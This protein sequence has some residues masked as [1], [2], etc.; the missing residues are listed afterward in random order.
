LSHTGKVF[1]ELGL[2]PNTTPLIDISALLDRRSDIPAINW[3][4]QADLL[5]DR[6]RH[7]PLRPKTDAPVPA[8]VLGK[9]WRFQGD[10]LR[11]VK[12]A[13]DSG[14]GGSTAE[15]MNMRIERAFAAKFKFRHGITP[16]SGASALHRAPAASGVRPG[17]E[18]VAAGATPVFV[19][20]GPDT[21]L[22]CPEGI[23]QKLSARRKT[24]MSVNPNGRDRDIRPI[25]RAGSHRVAVC[26]CRHCPPR[27]RTSSENI[28]NVE[29]R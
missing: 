6:R 3:F 26:G 8:R 27:K 12:D 16:N 19:V 5:K 29:K 1:H 13:H 7:T 21:F 4:R 24:F 28:E 25:T 18:V 15:A 11:C 17:D 20:A 9:G 23:R 2:T 22:T 14:F 10:A